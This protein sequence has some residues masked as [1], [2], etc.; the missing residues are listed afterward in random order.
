MAAQ[1]SLPLGGGVFVFSDAIIRS[2]VAI[3]AFGSVSCHNYR[4]EYELPGA[5]S[6]ASSTG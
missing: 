1:F 2:R 5:P 6:A 3:V 4:C